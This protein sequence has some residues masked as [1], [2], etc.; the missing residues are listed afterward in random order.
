MA[1]MKSQYSKFLKSG[2]MEVF[3]G[4]NTDSTW[5]VQ[6]LLKF[7]ENAECHNT[8]WPV[9]V[10]L[11]KPELAPYA[12]E[13]GI[14]VVIPGTPTMPLFDYWSLKKNGDFYFIRTY[15]ED[16]QQTMTNTGKNVFWFD[17]QIWRVSEILLYCLNLS[18][19]LQLNFSNKVDIFVNYYGLDSRVLS[20]NDPMRFWRD[21]D[22]YLCKSAK[23]EKHI[24]LSTD[25]L[26]LDYKETIYDVF[27]ELLFYFGQFPLNKEVCDSIVDNFLKARV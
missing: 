10:S 7:A 14:E 6:E 27:K 23:F 13:K 26:K 21:D 9:G 16:E 8:G 22:M 18:K 19:E 15:Q 12:T 17:T 20:C 2:Y 5:G 24:S 1:E 25:T 11:T 3:L 4:M